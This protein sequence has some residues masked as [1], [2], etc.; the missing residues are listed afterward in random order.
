M[1]TKEMLLKFLTSKKE[2]GCSEEDLARQL[3]ISRDAVKEAIDTLRSDGYIVDVGEN[4]GCRLSTESD[5]LTSWGIREHLPSSCSFFDITVLPEVTSTNALLRE[6]AVFGAKEG[7]VLAARA[8]TAGVGRMGRS[9]YSPDD[10]GV[11]LSLLL[12]PDALS[13]ERAVKITTIAAVATC[14]AI[15]AVSGKFAEIKWVNDIFVDGKKVSGILTEASFN[16]ENGM[17]DYA[18]LGVG[19]NVYSPREGFPKDLETVA[20]AVLASRRNGAKNRIAAE[21]LHRF[22]DYY[23]D[24]GNDDY[25][26]EYRRRSFVIG[27][28]IIVI[29]GEN[30]IGAFA[31]DIDDE[32]RLLVQYEDGSREILSSGE[33]SVRL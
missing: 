14:E 6:E 30:S 5:V 13:A 20:G 15:E 22:M 9:F 24:I 32:C 11:Y 16:P 25:I 4:Q 26:R 8:Q 23:R 29:S 3:G 21:F 31:L 10:T 28:E 12:R 27:K 7:T 2:V 1:E 17:I 33:I 18:V 19:I